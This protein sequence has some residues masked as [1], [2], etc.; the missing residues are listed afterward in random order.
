MPV[1]ESP[2]TQIDAAEPSAEEAPGNL[3]LPEVQS[4]D[5]PVADA[6]VPAS[7]PA[8]APAAEGGADTLPDFEALPSEPTDAVE[9]PQPVEAAPVDTDP[10]TPPAPEVISPTPTPPTEITDTQTLADLEK[11][12]ESPHVQTGET[13]AEEPPLPTVT[14]VKTG[15]DQ[16][17][18]ARDAVIAAASQGP[19]NA[20]PEPTHAVGSEGYLNVQDIPDTTLEDDQPSGS[21]MTP[22]SQQ[23]L[24]IPQADPTPPTSVA[25]D[26]STAPP[27]P[28]P[29]PLDDMTKFTAPK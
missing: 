27:V 14:D 22:P 2:E 29:L 10:V 13:P 23:D 26:P 21:P 5:A 19:Q 20:L 18:A 8:P 4:T 28:P 9:Q 17:E 24:T 6:A 16:L 15:G 11:A 1:A 25:Q 12:V 3:V 7:E